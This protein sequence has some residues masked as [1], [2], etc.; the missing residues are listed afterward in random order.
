MIEP[1]KSP[2]STFVNAIMPMVLDMVAK[3]ILRNVGGFKLFV[4]KLVIKYGRRELIE[5]VQEIMHNLDE[6][7]KNSKATKEYNEIVEKPDASREERKDAEGDFFN[8]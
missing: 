8:S 1:A 4:L 5:A 2:W 6:A 3:S 7:A